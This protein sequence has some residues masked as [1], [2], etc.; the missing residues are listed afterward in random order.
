MLWLLLP[1]PLPDAATT[2]FAEVPRD[3]GVH[4]RWSHD[5]KR[6][7]ASFIDIDGWSAAVGA[8]L[9]LPSLS[10]PIRGTHSESGSGKGPLYQ[11]W[12]SKAGQP[13]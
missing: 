11:P 4:W 7:A 6:P 12:L 8:V 9:K 13:T 10:F 3:V 2:P 5:S 1:L